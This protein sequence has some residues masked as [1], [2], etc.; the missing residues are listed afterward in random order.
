MSIG[1]Y[2]PRGVGFYLLTG[3]LPAFAQI[4]AVKP[5]SLHPGSAAQGAAGCSATEASSCAQAAAK[6][7]PIVM[8]E[9]PLEENLRRLVDRICGR[10]NGSAGMAKA[11]EG[12]VGGVAARGGDGRTAEG[13]A[14]VAEV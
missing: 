2:R 5:D 1:R 6:I 10:I 14:A 13:L 9:S 12:G 4:P 11:G 7:T 8:G 3:L